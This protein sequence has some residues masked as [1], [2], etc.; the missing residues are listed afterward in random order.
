[1][2][3]G[4]HTLAYSKTGELTILQMGRRQHG[5]HTINDCSGN[6][7]TRAPGQ[8]RQPPLRSSISGGYVACRALRPGQDS[9]GSGWSGQIP[10]DTV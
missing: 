4:H 1:M 10:Q 7:R 6:I 9:T 8:Y 2:G 3:S 5:R